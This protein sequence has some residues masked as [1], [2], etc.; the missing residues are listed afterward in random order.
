MILLLT[1]GSG[2]LGS[3]LVPRLA[4]YFDKIYLL[5][6]G[7]S[8]SSYEKL[9]HK[10]SH[11]EFVEGDLQHPDLFEDPAMRKKL[12]ESVTHIF[13]G[14]ALYDLNATRTQNY[15]NNVVGTQN[16]LSFIR[17]AR[18]LQRFHYVS[19][20]A[21]AGDFE[22]RFSE[23]ELN[24]GQKFQNSYAETKFM[25]EEMVRTY[26][27]S[28]KTAVSIYRLG[29]LVGHSK[30]GKIDKIDG[31]YYLID[32][33]KKRG[34]ATLALK[35]WAVIP[36]PYY[37]QSKV[38]IIPIDMA[39]QFI[40][41]SVLNKG[42][43]KLT[44]YHVVSEK[45]PSAKELL[46]DILSLF[47]IGAKIIPIP[48]NRVLPKVAELIGLPASVV[49]YFYGKTI[50]DQSNLI[51]DLPDADLGNYQNYKNKVITLD[52]LQSVHEKRGQR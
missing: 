41:K 52:A 50:Y 46:S 32:Q 13:H 47:G 24:V 45:L 20:I 2:F 10:Y 4:P 35:S 28:N 29:I 23:S 17:R 18:A 49:S 43:P 40:E 44:C 1:G 21:V 51:N 48:Y 38:P 30:T 8:F 11:I 36:F 7:A 19:T 3:N 42:A 16:V 14:G 37:P 25:A 5:A 15:L 34:V 27:K 33:L 9:Y 22:G 31:P 39:V 26:A 6:R 12:E